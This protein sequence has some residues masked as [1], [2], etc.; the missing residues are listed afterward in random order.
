MGGITIRQRQA[1]V[2]P[3]CFALCVGEGRLRTKNAR[4]AGEKH[5]GIPESHR[6]AASTRQKATGKKEVSQRFVNGG[7]LGPIKNNRKNW[8]QNEYRNANCMTRAFVTVLLYSPNEELFSAPMTLA[9]SNRTE[10]VTLN[11]SQLKV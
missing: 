6:S 5:A 8:L 4:S 1:E 2:E 7:N 9:G 11:I 10:F 3:E